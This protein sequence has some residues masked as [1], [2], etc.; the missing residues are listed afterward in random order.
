MSIVKKWLESEFTNEK[1]RYHY[2][3]SLRRFV[4]ITAGWSYDRAKV[5]YETW[6]ARYITNNPDHIADI[7]HFIGERIQRKLANKTI[8]LWANDVKI[9]LREHR[10]P[11]SND[12]WKRI[13]K[14]LLHR[15]PH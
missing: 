5:E 10:L 15:T 8:N 7:K 11:I 12:E 6:I 9:F 2:R 3:L 14:R 13:R 1:T 4:E